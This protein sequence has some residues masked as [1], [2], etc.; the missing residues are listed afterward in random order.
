[1]VSAGYDELRSA[2]DYYSFRKAIQRKGTANIILGIIGIIFGFIWMLESTINVILVLLGLI[3][4]GIGIWAR[5]KPT[6]NSLLFS[7]IALCIM[8]A[9]N[10]V[11]TVL[12]IIAF[13]MDPYGAGIGWAPLGIFW[14]A[15]QFA[16]AIDAFNRYRRY[17]AAPVNEFDKDWLKRVE[18]TVNPVVRADPKKEDDVIEFRKPGVWTT[19]IWKGKLTSPYGIIASTKGDDIFIIKPEEVSVDDQGRF[20]L[21]Q[22]RRANLT[23]KGNNF[24]GMMPAESITRLQYWK[25]PTRVINA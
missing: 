10:A 16:V 12:N 7:G 2:V 1:M 5:T 14:A 4:L 11:V 15:V 25:N 17:T 21:S 13:A 8:G 6:A 18:A 24:K 9:W 19:T 20:R 3:V 23:I 22:F